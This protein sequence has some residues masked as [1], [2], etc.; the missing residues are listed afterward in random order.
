[1]LGTNANAVGS[2]RQVYKMIYKHITYP[3]SSPGTYV[4]TSEAA[5]GDKGV[6]ARAT[7]SRHFQTKTEP[8]YHYEQGGL[9]RGH[10]NFT[11]S[12]ARRWCPALLAAGR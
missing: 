2:E 7:Q 1:V 9:C 12:P 11:W 8:E 5:K 3:F 6:D 10:L 4:G